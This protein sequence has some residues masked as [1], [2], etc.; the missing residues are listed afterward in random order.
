M[1]SFNEDISLPLYSALTNTARC[2][3]D[4]LSI[5][6]SSKEQRKDINSEI[7]K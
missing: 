1:S 7:K 5:T 4:T 2:A 6:D 3:W